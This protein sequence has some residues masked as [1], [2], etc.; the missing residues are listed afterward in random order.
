MPGPS[1]AGRIRL[2]VKFSDVLGSRTR[3]L[4]VC[5]ILPQLLR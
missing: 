4:P 5:S 3:G 1:A 2:I